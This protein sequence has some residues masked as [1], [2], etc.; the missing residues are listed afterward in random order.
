M[1]ADIRSGAGVLS[2]FRASG[3]MSGNR[4]SPKDFAKYLPT[5]KAKNG[6]G[7]KDEGEDYEVFMNC[8]KCITYI[9]CKYNL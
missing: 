5:L 1:E 4:R 7:G 2:G 3:R 9:K 8:R 6:N